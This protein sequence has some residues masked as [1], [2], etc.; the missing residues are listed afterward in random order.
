MST[1]RN[2]KINIK[3]FEKNELFDSIKVKNIKKF[4]FIINY[5]LPKL[6]NW[7]IILTIRI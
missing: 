1:N 3:E 2:L 6:M 5:G 7:I 4:V